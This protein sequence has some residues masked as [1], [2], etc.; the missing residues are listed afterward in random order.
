[1]KLKNELVKEMK[2]MLYICF[3]SFSLQTFSQKEYYKSYYLNGNL[4]EE[5][6]LV[7]NNKVDYWKFYYKNGQVKKQGHFINNL[8][9]K[10]WYFYRQNGIKEKEGHYINGKQNKWWLFYNKQGE[11]NYKCQLK[12]NKKNGYCLLYK[13]KR[14]VKAIRFKNGKKIN[15]WTDFSSFKKENNLKDLQ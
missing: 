5:G 6:W 2:W 11:V 13:K 15:E 3:L 9:V 8:P 12:D 1:M 4:K 10:Y 7:A 14:L